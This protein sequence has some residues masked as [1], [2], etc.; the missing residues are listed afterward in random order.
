MLDCNKLNNLETVAI[1]VC[2]QDSSN[3]FKNEITNKLFPYES[4]MY[5]HLNVGKEIT[6]VKLLLLHSNLTLCQQMINSK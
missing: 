5:I 6:D 1:L 4:Y 2:K 3:S